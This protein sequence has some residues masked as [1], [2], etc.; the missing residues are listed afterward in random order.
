M[1][2]YSVVDHGQAIAALKGSSF[3]CSHLW[4]HSD[5]SVHSVKFT[6][7]PLLCC[8]NT[9]II[10]GSKSKVPG[11]NVGDIAGTLRMTD[12]SITAWSSA[13]EA[14]A[15]MLPASAQRH[16]C[17][18]LGCALLSTILFHGNKRV[19]GL[20]HVQLRTY[21]AIAECYTGLNVRNVTGTLHLT[22]VLITA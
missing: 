18:E 7:Q 17:G 11:L 2:Y 12:F 3:D 22:D 13:P 8:R 20:F 14:R 1:L 5:L 10:T 21:W 19:H 4:R 15:S 16:P 6:D 9:T